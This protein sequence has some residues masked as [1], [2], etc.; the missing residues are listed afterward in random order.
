MSMRT[1]ELA[2]PSEDAQEPE[3]EYISLTIGKRMETT[4]RPGSGAQP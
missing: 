3:R 1:R 2:K 4:Q